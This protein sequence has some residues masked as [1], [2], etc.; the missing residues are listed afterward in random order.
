M[1]D[2]TEL[3]ST[4]I[5]AAGYDTAARELHVRFRNGRHAAYEG[6]PTFRTTGSST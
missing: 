5:A 3:A 1:V 4:S 6:V 2:F